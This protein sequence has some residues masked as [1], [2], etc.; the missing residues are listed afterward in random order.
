MTMVT[1]GVCRVSAASE[2]D[3]SAF[4]LFGNGWR[5]GKDHRLVLELSQSDTP[6]LRLDNF[7]SSI[8]FS[9]AEVL[10][11]RTPESRRVDFRD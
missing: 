6:F 5:F 2:K 1:R 3:C 11:P 10:L 4:D 9:A 8:S 7:P